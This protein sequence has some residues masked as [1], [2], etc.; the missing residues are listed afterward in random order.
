MEHFRTFTRCGGAAWPFLNCINASTY[1]LR[2][3]FVP[4]YRGAGAV[5]SGC[6]TGEGFHRGW[7]YTEQ[8]ST[9]SLPLA[10]LTCRMM[11]DWHVHKAPESNAWS[12]DPSLSICPTSQLNMLLLWD[13]DKVTPSC[14]LETLHTTSMPLTGHFLTQ[15]STSEN[16]FY[17]LIWSVSVEV[18]DLFLFSTLC[19]TP[20]FMCILAL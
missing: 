9:H 1:M 16:V 20:F 12:G 15:M 18:Y 2:N 11:C 13:K 8:V 3:I 4:A 5:C 17:P 14:T 6:A 10:P 7:P 19:K